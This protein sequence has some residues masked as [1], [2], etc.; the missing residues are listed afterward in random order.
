MEENAWAG[1]LPEF[2]HAELD[3]NTCIRLVQI[4][5]E[6]FRGD[7]SCTLQHYETDTR[8]YPDYVALS[9]VWGDSTPTQTIYINGLVYRVH[10][11][12]W[13]FLSHSRTK[14]DT[15]RTWLWTDFL[16]I[17]Q[18][19]HSEKNEQ[20]SR[21]G[22]IYAQAAYVISWLG[23]HGESMEALRFI[24]EISEGIDTGCALQHPWSSSESLQ[25]HKACDQLAF[26]EPYWERVWIL[27]EVACAEFCIVA[28]GDTSVNFGDLLRKMEIAMMRSVRFDSSS[29][30][31]RRMKRMK[32]LVD[33]RTSIQNGET[34]KI[35]KLI[36]KTS[37][38]QATRDQDKIY[39]LL[40]LASRLDSGF[41]SRALEV[42]QQKSLVD[43]WWDIIFMISDGESNTSIKKDMV[44]LEALFEKTALE[45]LFERLP[46]PRKHREL[47]M[48]SS[49]RRAQAETASQVSEAAYS[50]SI[51]AFL[52]VL[53]SSREYDAL[54]S[55]RQLLQRAWNMVT[56]HVRNYEHD[57]PGLQTRLGWCAYAGLAFTSCHHTENESPETPEKSLPLGWFCA[58]H[59]T[60]PPSKTTAKH[61]IMRT[62]SIKTPPE[63]RS[64]PDYCSGAEHGGARCDLSL[65]VLRIEQLG[66]TC[67]VR[68]ADTVQIDF[69][70]DCCGPNTPSLDP[71]HDGRDP[72]RYTSS[73]ADM[74][75]D[76]LA[77]EGIE[78]VTAHMSKETREPRE[79]WRIRY[80]GRHPFEQLL[81]YDSESD[82]EY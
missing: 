17:D 23:D 73:P 11:S 21:M 32:A 61:R 34:I 80:T 42:S 4:H 46:P 10:R 66:V 55:S 41:E 74:F 40:G 35:L 9:Y 5:A 64:R 28:S 60:D 59:S 43:V 22:D 54:V 51:Q 68:S 62:Y 79:R 37:F 78:E 24:V 49:V 14:K 26:R 47:D 30:R 52:G 31:D 63:D 56:T 70:C 33:L 72:F 12:L 57:V 53:Y 8:T 27:Q 67:L 50:S 69:Y 58:A 38:C 25:I 71:P 81:S 82:E 44:D 13:E 18:V 6:L 48:E 75:F 7:I 65:V 36:E 20:I 16:C 45:N 76:F 29:D 39:G 19:H 15:E 2:R 3:S 1:P 77:K